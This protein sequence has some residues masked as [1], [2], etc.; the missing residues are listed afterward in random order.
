[1]ATQQMPTQSI[2]STARI[3]LSLAAIGLLSSPPMVDAIWHLSR[4]LGGYIG[5]STFTPALR[6]CRAAI[7]HRTLLALAMTHF[8][9]GA[10]CVVVI[11]ASL[12]EGHAHTAVCR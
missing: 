1:M 11:A 5:P 3:A 4:V 6:L 10:A 8:S 9:S 7:R 12:D 2:V